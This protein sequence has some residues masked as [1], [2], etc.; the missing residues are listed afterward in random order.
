MAENK[1][2]RICWYTNYW[3]RPSGREGKS[4]NKKDYEKVT[5]YGHEEWL[6]DTENPPLCQDRCRLKKT[7]KLGSNKLVETCQ[8]YKLAYMASAAGS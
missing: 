8:L 6:L 7:T 4:R 1:I 2:A 5:G 3:Q